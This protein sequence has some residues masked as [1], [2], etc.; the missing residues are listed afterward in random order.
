[1]PQNEF[2]TGTTW[3]LN[4]KIGRDI[5]QNTNEPNLILALWLGAIRLSNVPVKITD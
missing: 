4:V 5:P 2:R 1:M 3:V